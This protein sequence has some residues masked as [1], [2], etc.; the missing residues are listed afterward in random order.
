MARR[1]ARCTR[2]AARAAAAHA[3]CAPALVLCTTMVQYVVRVCWLISMVPK[4]PGYLSSGFFALLGHGRPCASMQ[5]LVTLL[6]ALGVTLFW[7]PEKRIAICSPP[8]VGTS[9]SHAWLVWSEVSPEA[10]CRYGV[11]QLSSEAQAF[12]HDAGI[13]VVDS[14]YHPH[15]FSQL[16]MIR[17]VGP[18]S[19]AAGEAGAYFQS[20]MPRAHRDWRLFVLARDPWCRLMSGFSNKI[21]GISAKRVE[22]KYVDRRQ[23]RTRDPQK[24]QA[25]K[26]AKIP[27]LAGRTGRRRRRDAVGPAHIR[28]ARSRGAARRCGECAL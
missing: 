4:Y 6:P 26:H 5:G 17:A 18:P 13:E 8:K 25:G 1:R 21:L 12:C 22:T 16:K 20:L 14:L 27:S 23:I 10:A 19:R 11:A 3:R 24:R 15:N 7:L 28:A 9:F 2:R